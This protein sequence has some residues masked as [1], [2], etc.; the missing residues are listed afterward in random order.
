[1]HDCDCFLT[2]RF[3]ILIPIRLCI[4]SCRN[5]FVEQ[6]KVN[7]YKKCFDWMRGLGQSEGTY[8]YVGSNLGVPL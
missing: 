5:S 1:M 4:K 7:A 2:I 3:A 8:E 6:I